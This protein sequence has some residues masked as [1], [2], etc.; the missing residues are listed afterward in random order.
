MYMQ[1]KFLSRGT[2]LAPSVAQGVA[3]WQSLSV[4][5]FVTVS[6]SQLLSLDIDR[7]TL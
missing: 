1:I 2:F 7:Q 3:I 4:R 6:S 5:L